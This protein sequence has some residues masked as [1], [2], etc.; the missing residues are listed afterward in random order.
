MIEGADKV[1]IFGGDGC[2]DAHDEVL[3]LAAT[4]KAPVGYSFRGSNG[5]SMT[6]PMPWA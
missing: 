6:I 1:A 4:L 5:S 2:R 3:Q